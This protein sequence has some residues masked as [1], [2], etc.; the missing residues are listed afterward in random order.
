MPAALRLPTARAKSTHRRC[1]RH[2]RA[3]TMDLPHHLRRPEGRQRCDVRALYARGARLVARGTG[4]DRRAACAAMQRSFIGMLRVLDP[5]AAAVLAVV[6]GLAGGHLADP[7]PRDR[8]AAPD[9]R[10]RL[11][12]RAILQPGS[13]TTISR[14]AVTFASLAVANLT[15]V[16]GFGVLA[17]L[18]ICRLLPRVWRNRR[19]RC[20]PRPLAR[21]V[22]GPA[23]ARAGSRAPPGTGPYRPPDAACRTDGI[24]ASRV[25]QTRHSVVPAGPLMQSDHP[26]QPDAAYPAQTL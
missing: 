2:S 19:P 20:N 14:K 12:L 13:S 9:R 1:E 15:T 22:A 3:S 26:E 23:R 8:S 11:Q 25:V 10:G 7:A 18:G 21:G 17:L 4:A 16:A 24:H 5:L 6:A